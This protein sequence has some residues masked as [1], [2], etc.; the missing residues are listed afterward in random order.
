VC[1]DLPGREYN[2]PTRVGIPTL[3]L[4][5]T[6]SFLVV[7]VSRLPWLLSARDHYANPDVLSGGDVFP[8][9]VEEHAPAPDGA[10]IYVSS[11]LV[12]P[13]PTP[14]DVAGHT[15]SSRVTT[16]VNTEIPRPAV[17]GTGTCKGKQEGN[18]TPASPGRRDASD[19]PLVVSS[20]PAVPSFLE[21]LREELREDMA[22]AVPTLTAGRTPGMLACPGMGM[23][24][25]GNW[26]LTGGGGGGDGGPDGGTS[27]DSRRDRR[28]RRSRRSHR[29]VAPGLPRVTHHPGETGRRYVEHWR[30]SRFLSTRSG[31]TCSTR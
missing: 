4:V 14:A 6:S 31:T 16:K 27:G 26:V 29:R 10:G 15:G 3:Y 1:V 9:Y 17:A 30:I 13:P 25:S 7:R 18:P 12:P 19:V 23:R 21:S 22:G 28:S 24:S 11:V 5:A 8:A 20:S 2:L